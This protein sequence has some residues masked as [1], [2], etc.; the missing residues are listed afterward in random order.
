MPALV[1]L[2]TNNVTVKKQVLELLSALCVYNA[3][4]YSRA[5]DALQHYKAFNAGLLATTEMEL[6]TLTLQAF[7]VGLLDTTEM[8]LET[9]TLQAFNAGLLATTEM[10]L[11]TLTLQAFNVGLLA[12]TE[13]ELETLTLQA[14]N[15]GLLDTTEM[16]LETLTLQAFNE[17]KGERYRLNVVVSELRDATSVEYQNA[18]VAFINCLIISTPQLKDRIRIRNEFIG[19]KLLP[20]LGDLRERDNGKPPS[21]HSTGIRTTIVPSSEVQSIVGMMSQTI[22]PP[23]GK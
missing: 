1:A 16:E 2:D 12:T 7:N 15:A 10:E 6:E 8:E 5:L 13:M 11:E 14:F 18:L 21:V 22:G 23:V 20:V 19:L 3:E 9:L 4:G 17:L